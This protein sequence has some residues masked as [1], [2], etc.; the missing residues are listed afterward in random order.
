MK[1]IVDIFLEIKDKYSDNHAVSDESG[2]LT[3]RELDRLSDMVAGE[4][5]SILNKGNPKKNSTDNYNIGVVYPREKEVLAA[6]LGIMRSGN[7]Y[8]FVSPDVPKE[9]RDYIIEDADAACIITSAKLKKF[10]VEDSGIPV[11]YMEDILEDCKDGHIFHNY[12][13]SDEKQ[14]AYITYTSGSTGN[15]KGVVDTYYYIRNHINA[16]HQYYEPKPDEC[17]GNIVS[18]SYAASTYDLFSGLTV[19]CNLYI[20]SDEELLNQT[21]LTSRITDNNIT[22]MFM[23]PSMIPIV[24]APGAKLPIKCIITAG[25]KAKKIP[26]ISARMVEIYGSSEAAAVIGR[27]TSK[28]DPWNLLGVPFPGTTIYLLDEEGKLITTPDTVGEVCIVNDA[29]AVEY[30][31]REEET[32]EKF[33]ECPFDGHSRMYRSGDLMQFDKDGNYYY[34]GRKDNMTKIN[35]QRVEMGEVEATIVKHPKVHDAICTIITRN[36]ADMLI[37]YYIPSENGCEPESDDLAAFVAKRLPR[38]MVPR[39]YVCMDSFPKNVNGKVE[40][41]ALPMPDFDRYTSKVEGESYEE[42]RLLEA[43]RKLMPD[44]SFGVT[45]DLMRLGMDSI[46]AVQFVSMIEKYDSRITVS[47]VMKRKTIREILSAP[48]E[49]IWFT[50][51]FDEGKPTMVLSH[52]IVNVS[53]FSM[54]YEEWGKQFNLL[55]IEPFIDHIDTVIGKYDYDDLIDYYI[56]E[57]NRLLEGKENTLFGFAGFSFGGQIALDLADRWQKKTGEEKWVVMGD[58]I[59]PWI[60]PGKVF[61]VLTE[62]DPYI[63]MVAERSRM[64]GDSV[65]REPLELIIRKQNL[66]LDLMRTMKSNTKYDGPVLFLDAK[67]DYDDETEKLK[68][69][70]VS[71][72]FKNARV[73]EFAEYF[74][75][76]LYMKKEMFTFYSN[77]F[78]MLLRGAKGLKNGKPDG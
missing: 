64:Y 57:I 69:S 26:D 5:L 46:M 15:P 47:D 51:P 7:C 19:G 32:R 23:I 18:F 8:F 71:G 40:R 58:T 21:L 50:A 41:K 12:N 27:E 77:Y 66:V 16:R 45:D 33:V 1:T 17:I 62:D 35:G 34:C 37:C 75:N 60:Y 74:H 4:I 76:D 67:K 42:K 49:I 43:A 78:G 20:F 31:N 14:A 68:L 30:R 54:L 70:V 53:G 29:L 56:K 61:P 44:I 72:L 22:T 2:R 25:E 65:V 3:Y 6:F 73:V 39:Y 55:A 28:E 38:Y 36:R 59:I 11:I 48:K 13:F 9:R 52:G 10:R 63:K 24:F